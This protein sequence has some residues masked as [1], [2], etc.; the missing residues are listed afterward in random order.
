MTT[1]SDSYPPIGDYA[2]IGDCHSLALVSLDGSVDWLT[3]G[4]VDAD[5]AFGALLDQS[6][7]GRFRIRARGESECSREYLADTNILCTRQRTDDGEITITDFM[8]VGRS[9][10]SAEHDFTRLTAPFWLVRIVECCRGTVPVEVDFTPL[11]VG[12]GRRHVRMLKS[13]RGLEVNTGVELHADDVELSVDNGRAWGELTLQAGDRQVF[14]LCHAVNA[15]EDSVCR[16]A[17]DLL[18]TTSAY[19]REWI[20]NCAYHGPYEA[21]VR[22]SAL[23][24]KLL[25]YAP[26]GALV[27]AG[28]TSLP[29]R[30]GGTRNWDYRY[31]WLRDS[32]FTLYV[33]AALDYEGEAERHVSFLGR[34]LKMTHPDVCVMYGV[35]AESTIEEEEIDDFHGYRGSR[36]VRRGNGALFQEQLDMYGEV[37]DASV[38]FEL[39]GSKLSSD[40]SALLLR[41]AERVERNW[42]DPG[43]GIW[44]MRTRPRQHTYSKIMCWVA[45]DRA[46]RLFEDHAGR[47]RKVRDAIYEDILEHAVHDGHLA[48]SYELDGADAALLLAPMAGFSIEPELLR[49]TVDFIRE[50]L[51]TDGFLRRYDVEDGLDNG[52]GA[53][54]ACSFWLADALAFLGEPDEAHRIIERA[55]GAANDVGLMSEQYDPASGELLGNFPQALSHLGLIRSALVLRLVEEGG[56]DALEGAHVKRVEGDHVAG[57]PGLWDE[58]VS[59]DG[60]YRE[61]ATRASILTP[62]WKNIED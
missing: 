47:F 28:T 36:P 25:T 24:L 53:F 46:A 33:L 8:P 15:T 51:E 32:A 55:L 29:E 31:S 19:W 43:C 5:P 54:V 14:V 17:D 48:H 37:L 30:I 20:A 27:A 21:A 3:L 35:R 6:R 50:R 62:F 59:R 22:R 56:S 42:Q 11:G 39:L 44:E 13:E 58:L 18:A 38:L 9:P 2:A 23:A 57:M 12:W 40:T 34:C 26:T 60:H 49:R 61:P 16:H 10:E 1:S 4:R 7:G 45:M 52:E 41:L